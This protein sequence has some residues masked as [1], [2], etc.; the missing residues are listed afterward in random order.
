MNTF[1]HVT[2]LLLLGLG[3]SQGI[4]AQS[5]TPTPKF[6]FAEPALS[7]DGAEIAFV[8]G[9]D[10]WTVPAAGGEAHLLVAHADNETRP[11]YSPDGKYLAFASTRSGNGDIYLLTLETGALRRLT[12]DDGGESLTAW[13]ND[14]KVVYFQSTS[15]DISGMNDIYR[16]PIIGGTPM[17]VTADRYASEFFGTPS[18]DGTTLAFSARGIAAAQWWR[19]GSS[20]LDQSEIW[21][22][23]IGT[24][25]GDRP[26]YER[27][28]ESGAK[29]LWPLWSPDGQSI[30]YMSDRSGSQNLWTKPLKGQPTMLTT[31]KDG[32]VIW[33]SISHNGKAIVFE[34]DFQIWKYDVASKQAAPVAIRLRGAASGLSVDH[35]K[36]STQFRDLA[37]SPDGKKVAF[38]AHGEVFAASAKDGGDAIRVSNSPALESQLAWTP[39]SRTLLYV[40]T[41]NGTANLYQY[42]F[43][44]QTESRLTDSPLDDGA[45]V[46][47]PDGK[48]VAFLRNGQELRVMDLSTK[49]DRVLYKGYLGRGV[50]AGQ[51]TVAW[52]PDGKWLAFAAYGTKTFRNVSV[53]PAAGGDSQPVSFLANTFGGNVNW[54]PDGK[55]I[56]FGTNQRTETAQVARVDLVPRLPKFKEDQ[57][58]DLFNEEVP[59]TMRPTT[60]PVAPVTPEKS[61]AR[62]TST[63]SAK[64][65]PVGKEA[66][67]IVF[68]GIRQR[69]S[70]LPVG[71][72]VDAQTISKD[73]KTLLLVAS[74]AGRQNLYTYS[75]D[76]SN[77]ERT[78][79]RQLTTTPG[80]KS[81]AQF[82][83]DGKEVFY[84]EQGRIQSISLERREPKPLSV[85]A[86]MDVDFSTEKI[87][88]FRQAWDVQNKGFYDPEFHGVDW[89]GV[90]KNYEPLAAG[91]RTSDELRRLLSLMV[92]ELNASHSGVSGPQGSID[93][94][95]GRLGLRFDRITYESTGKLLITEVVA[96]GPTALAG[97]IKPGDYLLAVDGKTIDASTNLEELL[98]NKINHRVSLAIA[99]APTATPRDVNVL[100][101]NSATEKGLLYKQWVQ[102]QRD[103]VNK[104]SGGRLGYVHMFDMSA[105]SLNQLYIDLDADNHAREGV[106]V[107]VRNNNGGFVNA[108]AIDVFARKGYMTMT[109]RGLPSAPARTQLGQRAL[110]K[111]TILV[112]NQHSLSDAED[113]T[114]G[115]RTLKLGKVVGE[116]T[117]GWI[118]YTSAAQLIDGSSIR[119]PFSRI[120]DNTGKNMELAPRPVDIPVSRPIGE[121]Y[122][123]Q[124]TQ[125]D[126]AVKELVKQLDDAKPNKVTSGK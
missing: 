69:L 1:K 51:G 9:G 4:Q 19:K 100:P 40:S 72:E 38:T 29:E 34:R 112:T 64:A 58:R 104:A 110:E 87:Q 94:T 41:R 76:D 31:F 18:P 111:P 81:N 73:G 75:L 32:R 105:E 30:Y 68:E 6:A 36:L 80:Q 37:V 114:E 70:L 43:S 77:G 93:I 102:Q 13:S 25:K 15:R 89:Q 14:S 95:T 108:Y 85:S 113:F 88:V 92:G 61:P 26:S 21:T 12:F 59:R 3:S 66:T 117:A 115:Y 79:A 35:L 109:S 122:T 97:S 84:L 10:I 74:V 23:K 96:L 98:S 7:P 8:S 118:I 11:L 53:V 86:E 82:T 103:Y 71:I 17:P 99:S 16:V 123:D 116:P 120:T 101:V 48:E 90:R 22:C 47:S 106:V 50:F 55:Y 24:K 5:D 62:D 60:T 119:L 45:P 125:L 91:A 54:S 67:Q 39:N 27:L 107:D 28:T 33:P 57:F 78:I 2:L 65:K 20:H 46:V 124:N 121:S 49:K 56:L 63:T 42:D 83:A 126:V 44:T 52:S